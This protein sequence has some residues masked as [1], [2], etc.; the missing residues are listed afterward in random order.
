MLKYVSRPTSE[1]SVRYILTSCRARLGAS[2]PFGRRDIDVRVRQQINE[3]LFPVEERQPARL[4]LFDD[5]NF[6]PIEHR[7]LTALELLQQRLAL[8]IICIR[9]FVVHNVPIGRISFE[10]DL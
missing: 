7:Q 8:L 10:N 4:F 9:F 6:N 3:I 1:A 5:R 2:L